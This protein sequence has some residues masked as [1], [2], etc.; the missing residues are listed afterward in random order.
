MS[1][2]YDKDYNRMLDELARRKEQELQQEQDRKLAEKLR[3]ADRRALEKLR[4]T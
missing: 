4:N 2:P 1:N 3:E